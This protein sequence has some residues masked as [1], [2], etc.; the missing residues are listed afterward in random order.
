MNFTNLEAEYTTLLDT[1][2]VRENWKDAI[3]R[4]AR[5]IY[6][7]KARY[8][9]VSQVTNVPWQVIGLIHS[10]EANLD[11]TKNLYNGEPLNRKTRLVPKGKGPFA[12]WEESAIGALK[13]DGLDKIEDWSD[14]MVCYA[15]EKYNGFGYRLRRTG[16]LSPYLWSGT[17]HYSVGKFVEI[18]KNGKYVSVYKPEVKSA[19]I[20]AVPLYLRLKEID[21]PKKEV[22]TQSSKLT[23][24]KRI[25]DWFAGISLSGI[26]AETLDMLGPI[27]EFIVENK[28][29]FIGA[30]AAGTLYVLHKLLK[31]G[32]KDYQEGRYIPSGQKE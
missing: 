24:I 18:P 23:L 21:I 1:M 5:G 8:E 20:G 14:A 13:Y 7:N 32:I 27:K 16:V 30:T 29:I 9:E 22:V 15:L 19:Q 6:A 3:D 28:Y 31:K 26:V 10:L 12:S 11:F 25:R 17:T 2:E 4:K